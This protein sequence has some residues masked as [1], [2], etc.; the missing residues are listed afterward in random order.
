MGHVNVGLIGYKFMGKAHSN[1]YKSVGMFFPLQNRVVMKAIC[2]RDEAA[3]RKAAETWGWESY[4]TDWKKLVGRKDI[5]VVDVSTPGNLHAE[6]AIAAARAGK[7]VVC[8]KP[9]ANSLAEARRM[10]KAAAKAGVK[11]M[12]FYNYRRVPAVAFARRMIREGKLGDIY[13]F[14]GAYLQDWITDPEFPLVWRLDKKVAGSGALGDIGAHI[15]DLALFLVGEIAEV[16][17]D[18]KTFI[19]KRPLPRSGSA[20]FAEKKTGPPQLGTVTVDDAATILARFRSGAMGTFT[21]TRFATGRK[22]ANQFEI[23]GSRGALAFNLEALNE[24]YHYSKDDAA[25]EQGFKKILVTDSAHPYIGAWWPPG[26]IIGYEHT[27]TNA[28]SDFFRCLET[29]E[30]ISPDFSEGVAVQAVLDAVEKSAF[31]GRWVSVVSVG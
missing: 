2:G 25:T 30:P 7:H 8:E 24:L 21:A 26:H 12:V 18:M 28:L 17:A 4:E 5:D 9:L 1:A 13:H 11:N 22:N 14:R 15:I 10:E 19:K 23:Y 27:F 3:V 6:M 20:F 31:R 29:G 16:V